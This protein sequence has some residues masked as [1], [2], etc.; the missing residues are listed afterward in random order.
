MCGSP[1]PLLSTCIEV[2][3]GA[4]SQTAHDPLMEITPSHAYTSHKMFAGFI[5][6]MLIPEFQCI[7]HKTGTIVSG[8]TS[9]GF[10][11]HKR[12]YCS[13]FDVF[14]NY[15][16][17]KPI[18]KFMRKAGYGK[19]V[20][21]GEGAQVVL[22]FHSPVDIMLEFHSIWN[23][24]LLIVMNIPLHKKEDRNTRI[25]AGQPLDLNVS[26]QMLL[27]TLLN[28]MWATIFVGP[29]PGI[30]VC[31]IWVLLQPPNLDYRAYF[32][33]DS[34]VLFIKDFAKFVCHTLLDTSR[35]DET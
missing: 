17:Y 24:T 21:L 11:L 22:A 19:P 1:P 28:A 14:L 8:S 7:Q 15:K 32:T 33:D 30:L 10:L 18:R 16:D 29:S 12:F 27:C 31:T 9:L 25:K 26:T 3:H 6:H 35:P 13:N 5:P 34:K 20:L 4:D 23:L 2:N